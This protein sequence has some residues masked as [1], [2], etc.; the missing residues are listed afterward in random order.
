MGEVVGKAASICTLENCDPRDVY[1]DHL[2]TLLNL[3]RLPGKARRSV[4]SGPITIPDDAMEE[5]GPN[6]PMTGLNP[7]RIGGIVVDDD[8]A[9]RTG[10]VDQGHG[11]EGLCW[12]WISLLAIQ[13]GFKHPV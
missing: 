3:L 7:A 12:I 11:V 4:P 13:L 9:T 10:K 6:G 5:A 1:D 2:D 8:R